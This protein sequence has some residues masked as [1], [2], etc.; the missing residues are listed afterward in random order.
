MNG[1]MDG[2]MNSTQLNVSRNSLCYR[3]TENKIKHTGADDVYCL[4]SGIELGLINILDNFVPLSMPKLHSSITLKPNSE[5][6]ALALPAGNAGRMVP[7]HQQEGCGSQAQ[8]N[9][10]VAGHQQV[11]LLQRGQPCSPSL[12]HC[13][14]LPA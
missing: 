2:R 5:L 6:P 11:S 8:K 14:L 13:S 7:W 4:K 1:S 10:K 12:Q 3:E 9:S